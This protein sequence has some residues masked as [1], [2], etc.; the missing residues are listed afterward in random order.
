LIEHDHHELG[1]L[2]LLHRQKTVVG[3][4]N[5]VAVVDDCRVLVFVLV[6]LQQVVLVL[7]VLGQILFG[8]QL[9]L[10]LVLLG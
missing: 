8:D 7:V 5:V 10:V 2:P 1:F 9:G 4:K 3:Q 6:S